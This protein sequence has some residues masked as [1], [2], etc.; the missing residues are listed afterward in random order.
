[1]VCIQSTHALLDLIL[2]MT[3][4]KTRCLPVI[5]YT[6]MFYAVVVLIKLAL[7]THNPDSSIGAVLDPE[8]LKV[9]FYLSTIKKS[10]Q[11]AMGKE[12]FSVP[13]CFLAVHDRVTAWYQ[14]HDSQAPDSVNDLLEPMTHLIATGH[15]ESCNP[16]RVA[17]SEHSLQT[18]NTHG[19]IQSNSGDGPISNLDIP[20]DGLHLSSGLSSDPFEAFPFGLA[21]SSGIQNST[22]KLAEFSY[23]GLTEGYDFQ[24][25]IW[26]EQFPEPPRFVDFGS[27]P[28]NRD[29][30]LEHSYPPFTNEQGDDLGP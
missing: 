24:E 18:G 12:K 11:A 21:S 19:F 26:G 25:S 10:L 6:R 17:R 15:S 20:Y 7:C 5:V 28:S 2:S 1:M 4:E 30:S 22:S 16:A 3:T 13:S 8:S 14:G 29:Q 23:Y 9:T 27:Y